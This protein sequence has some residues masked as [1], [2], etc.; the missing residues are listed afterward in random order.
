MRFLIVGLIAALTVSPLTLLNAA[1]DEPPT[2]PAEA[3]VAFLDSLTDAQRADTQR[4]FSD[5]LRED[6][7][8]FPMPRAGVSR[9][10]LSPDQRSELDDLLE[11]FLT[12]EGQRKT[13]ETLLL[14]DLLGQL[15]NRTEHY[16]SGKYHALIFGNPANET[17]PWGFRF[18]GH[19]LSLNYTVVDGQVSFAVAPA[20][21]GANPHYVIHGPHAGLRVLAA[22]EDTAR[23][24]MMSLNPEQQAQALIADRAPR[25]ILTG[26]DSVARLDEFEGVP[27]G[28]L[29]AEQQ[30]GLRE[31]INI[32]LDNHR[33]Q[34]TQAM[35]DAIE[36]A[37]FENVHF[38][39]AGSIEPGQAHYY[40]VHGPTFLI[41]Y[42]NIQNNANHSHTVLRDLHNDFGRD[43][44][45]EHHDHHHDK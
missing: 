31:L 6:W 23:S 5:P 15:Q 8:F 18:E 27:A 30:A 39:W 44:L 33:P 13:R 9:K 45:R 41:E 37:G 28:D 3:A 14:E 21:I 10:D 1:D 24:L 42:D 38:A 20:F 25:D 29:S 26:A 22:E 36:A 34:G 17:E 12:A 35:R 32:Y 40:R 16:N 43:W 4:E 7:H 11:S 2:N 19:H